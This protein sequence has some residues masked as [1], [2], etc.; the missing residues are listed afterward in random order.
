MA[1]TLRFVTDDATSRQYSNAQVD[2]YRGLSRRR[3]PWRPPAKLT[4]RAR[5]SHP[6]GHLKGTAGFGFWNDPFLMTGARL[7]ALPQA[8][9]FFYASPP[10]DMRL[11]LAHSGTWLEGGYHR[12]CAPSSASVGALCA[13]SL[14]TDERSTHLPPALAQDPAHTQDTRNSDT[15]RHDDLAQ[16]HHR[17]GQPER[18]FSVSGGAQDKDIASA[19]RT[20]T[21]GA[22]GVCRVAGQPISGHHSLGTPGLGA[23]WKP[24]PPV[25]GR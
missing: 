8:I 16:L 12:F 3:F 10:S 9:W 1:P 21:R 20:F 13:F 22:T 23:T 15:G 19:A 6:A 18:H 14:A 4:V 7:P 5:F 17:M 11:D 25:D 2:D 24:G